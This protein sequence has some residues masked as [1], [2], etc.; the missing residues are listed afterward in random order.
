MKIV[1]LYPLFFFSLLMAL[2]SYAH[3]KPVEKNAY[4]TYFEERKA[5]ITIPDLISEPE[6]ISRPDASGK[7]ELAEVSVKFLPGTAYLAYIYAHNHDTGVLQ[8][9]GT[10]YV[11]SH[12]HT[13]LPVG[14]KFKITVLGAG[15]H[16]RFFTVVNATYAHLEFWGTSDHSKY[17][18]VGGDAIIEEDFYTTHSV[19]GCPD[20]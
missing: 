5:E 19:H 14:S 20:P 8:N 7:P 6:Y 9:F 11:N 4:N 3:D 18:Y 2:F 17:E 13:F 15:K 16:C 1:R 10:F 12:W